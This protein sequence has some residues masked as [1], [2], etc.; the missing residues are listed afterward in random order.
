MKEKIILQSIAIF[1]SSARV[2]CGFMLLRLFQT[3][4]RLLFLFSSIFLMMTGLRYLANL[5]F[6]TI[7]NWNVR[8]LD[9]HDTLNVKEKE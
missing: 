8:R 6:D 5:S 4:P 7:N 9:R 1:M 2:V 3:N